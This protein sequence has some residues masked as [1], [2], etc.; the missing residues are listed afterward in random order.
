[1]DKINK[2]SMNIIMEEI[3]PQEL[4]AGEEYY[5]EKRNKMPGTSGKL[6]GIFSLRDFDD[7]MD[8]TWVSFTN[9]RAIE[10]AKLPTG[11]IIQNSSFFNS[12]D[13]I[14]YKP[15]AQDISFKVV[16]NNKFGPA[17]PHTKKGGKKYKQRKTK[18]TKKQRK[19]KK[20]RKR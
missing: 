4:Q 15:S 19:T 7:I 12:E 17:G 3:D 20:T 1:M 9:L 18:K 13:Y 6:I 2:I 11:K 10:G 16:M 5:I 8:I 14:F